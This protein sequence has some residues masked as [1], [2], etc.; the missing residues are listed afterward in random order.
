MLVD[1]GPILVFFLFS[2]F[3]PGPAIV[4]GI[5]ATI[6]FMVVMPIAL[7]YSWIRIRH[8]SLVLWMTAVLVL[9]FGA[10]TIYFHDL[11]FIQ[12]KPSFLYAIMSVGLGYGLASGKPLL[13]L[14]M[15]KAY[16]GLSDRGWRILTI[17]YMIFFAAMAVANVVVWWLFS[18]T[19]WTWF[20]FP[21]V[22][23]LTFLFGAA[24]I[25]MLMKHGL[26]LEKPAEEAPSPPQP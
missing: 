24:N 5:T 3:T 13:E 15:G 1:F 14:L 26:Q 22:L 25:P 20:K 19:V 9:F 18:Y 17:N 11:N 21:G 2:I 10:L 16:P 12:L 6:A 7:I 4:K 23:I 8:I